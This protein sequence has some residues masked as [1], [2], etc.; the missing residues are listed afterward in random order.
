MDKKFFGFHTEKK[1]DYENGFYITSDISRI[2]KLIAHYELYKMIVELPGNIVEFGVFKGTSIIRFATYRELLESQISRKIIGFDA[3]GKFPEQENPVDAKFIEEWEDTAGCGIDIEDLR[4]IFQYKNLYNYEFIKG[5]IV[6]T[7]PRYIEEHPEL[8]IAL[9]HI[10]VDVYKPTITILENLFDKV[11][12][13]GII[14]FDDFGTEAGETQAI[15]EFFDD[16][17][18]RIKKLSISHIP[19]Y[20]IKE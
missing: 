9:L 11:V 12:R 18:L 7:L 14:I 5:D 16:R 19:G 2:A 4:A 8:K 15:D 1:W 17:D 10:D 20:I 13:G 3:F 6:E